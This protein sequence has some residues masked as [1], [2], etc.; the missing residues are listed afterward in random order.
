[1]QRQLRHNLPLQEDGIHFDTEKDGLE[2]L[3]KNH[4]ELVNFSKKMIQKITIKIE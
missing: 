1:M 4:Q 2:M 3:K